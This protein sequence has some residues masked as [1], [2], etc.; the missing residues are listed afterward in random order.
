MK[1]YL[2]DSNAVTSLINHR[3]PVARRVREA[4]MRGNRVGTCEP[5]VAELR[6]GLELS[7][8]R[9]ANMDRLRR[10][11]TRLSCWPLDRK[12][13][14]EYGGVAADLRRRGRPMQVI[15]MM[16]AAI[17]LTLPNCTV[18]TTDTDLLAIPGLDVENWESD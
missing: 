5:V 11:L 16:L 14:E 8:S 4:R 13:S 15:D 7:E 3:E 9:D 6:F 17:A 12:A 1:R 2:L 18:V 10:G